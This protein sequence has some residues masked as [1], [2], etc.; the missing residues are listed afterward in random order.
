MNR[1]LKPGILQIHT[2]ISVYCVVLIA[3]A[4]AGCRLTGI[5]INPIPRVVAVIV[6]AAGSIWVPAYW[7]GRGRIQARDAA[8]TFPWFV[9]VALTLPFPFLAAARI[10]MPL[11]DSLFARMDEA[12]GIYVPGLAHW[13]TNHWFG[14]LLDRSYGCLELLIAVAIL[15]PA[16]TGKSKSANE[17]LTANLIV[18][19]LALPLFTLLPAVGP[20]FHYHT[21]ATP[22]QLQ[23]QNQL[24]QLR[25]SGPYSLGSEGAGI[26]SFPSFHAIWAILSARALWGFRF[27]RIPVC[28]LSA[29]IVAST[30]TTGWHYLTDVLAGAVLAALSIYLAGL[31]LRGEDQ[32]LVPVDTDLELC[33][34]VTSSGRA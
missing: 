21:M 19:A 26:V 22:M 13:A 18:C 4:V 11:R 10:G 8:L 24:L 32:P 25:G 27:A 23:V 29:M 12:M 20:W 6:I 17:F 3:L 14:L 7:Q 2:W 5:T 16:F 33:T 9:L 34:E 15:V 28:V 1:A 31:L 30:L